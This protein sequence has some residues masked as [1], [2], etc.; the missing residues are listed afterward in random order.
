MARGGFAT[1]AQ[2]HG[3][4]RV[5]GSVKK[6][7]GNKGILAAR[8]VRKRVEAEQRNARTPPERHRAYRRSEVA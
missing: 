1:C 3:L 6:K 8:R 4:N 5:T 2:G 7:G